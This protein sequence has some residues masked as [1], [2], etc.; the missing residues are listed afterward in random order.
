MSEKSVAP[1]S[2]SPLLRVCLPQSRMTATCPLQRLCVCA[3]CYLLLSL[4]SCL[5][6]SSARKKADSVG[7]VCA[8]WVKLVY[9]QKRPSVQW[10]SLASEWHSQGKQCYCRSCLELGSSV[11]GGGS[12]SLRR[13]ASHFLR[14]MRD[15]SIC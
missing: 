12:S 10:C 8:H 7:G 11:G 6:V 3:L 15:S 1:A 4:R 13:I 2:P 9:G 5:H 14:H